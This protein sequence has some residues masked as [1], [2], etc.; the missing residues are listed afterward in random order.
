MDICVEPA[1]AAPKNER[2]GGNVKSEDPFMPR[3]LSG[4]ASGFVLNP[5]PSGMQIRE[6]R[7]AVFVTQLSLAVSLGSV[8]LKRQLDVKL[9]Y[10]I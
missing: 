6:R 4:F 9:E 2:E 5:R 3:K 7:E 10:S 1:G 8:T